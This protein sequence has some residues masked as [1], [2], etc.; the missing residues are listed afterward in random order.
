MNNEI[1]LTGHFISVP[2]QTCVQKQELTSS[3]KSENGTLYYNRDIEKKHLRE[4]IQ[5]LQ[6]KIELNDSPE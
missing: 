6:M 4:I 1:Y 5:I 3:S 2:Y